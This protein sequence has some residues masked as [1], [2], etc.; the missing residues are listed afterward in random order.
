MI[1]TAS[2]IEELKVQW[3]QDPIWDIENTEGF[4]EHRTEL[5]AFHDAKSKEWLAKDQ[6]DLRLKAIDLGCP[7]NLDIAGYVIWLE[8]E[9]ESLS[10]RIAKIEARQ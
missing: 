7:G 3:E 5:N 2:E 9:L 6:E 8:G 1:R 4:E 10:N